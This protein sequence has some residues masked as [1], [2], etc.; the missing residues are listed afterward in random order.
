M[1]LVAANWIAPS[2]YG[3]KVTGLNPVRGHHKQEKPRLFLGRGSFFLW[4]NG[5]YSKKFWNKKKENKPGR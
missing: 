5:V 4:K 3:S 2:D 1:A